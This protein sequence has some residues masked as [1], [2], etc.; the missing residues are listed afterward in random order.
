VGEHENDRTAYGLD[1][2]P[3]FQRGHVWTV[4]QQTKFVEFM[5]R[6]GKTTPIMFNSPSYSGNYRTKEW[7][8]PDTIL[9]VDGKQR[10]EA[11]RAF[12]R[13]EL[14]VFGGH[15]FSDFEDG[16]RL[17]QRTSITYMVNHIFEKKALL[18]WYLEMNEGHIAHATEE[19]ERVRSM[20]KNHD[21]S[22]ETGMSL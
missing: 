10:L 22:H 8:L 6:G 11:C 13:N 20:I 2:N 9:I 12:M 15:L 1:L 17:A 19:L 18:Q 4:E 16:E 5:I 7:D 3:D 14:K 21:E